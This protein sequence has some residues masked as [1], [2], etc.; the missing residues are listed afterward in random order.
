[1][2]YT[3]YFPMLFPNRNFLNFLLWQRKSKADPVLTAFC[4]RWSI[5]LQICLASGEKLHMLTSQLTSD[6][7]ESVN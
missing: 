5:W 4:L 7:P 6:D 2:S 1:M 3:K